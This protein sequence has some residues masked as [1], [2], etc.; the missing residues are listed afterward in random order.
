VLTNPTGVTRYLQNQ[1]TFD[2]RPEFSDGIKTP[3]G[4]VH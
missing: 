2:S 4:Q 1:G 3:D